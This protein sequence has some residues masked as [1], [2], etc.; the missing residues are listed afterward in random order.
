MILSRLSP[1]AVLMLS[2]LPL[3]A[4]DTRQMDAHVHGVG[5]LQIAIEGQ[6]V[7]MDITVPGAD[8]VGF[9]HAPGS[10]ADHAA[11]DAAL[12]QFADAFTLFTVAGDA[13]CTAVT[14]VNHTHGYGIE[15]DHD[16]SDEATAA[17]DHDHDHDHG[18][19]TEAAAHDHDHDHGEDHA[20]A[21]DH[22]DHDHAADA[23]HDDH[24]HDH[25]DAHDDHDHA[26]GDSH[27]EFHAVYTLTCTDPTA[28]T[29]IEF[30]YFDLFANA[31]E[32]EVEI[33]SDT[34]AMSASVLRDAPRLSLAGAM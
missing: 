25:A 9:E 30:P 24:G 1:A 16:H 8:I 11:I 29:A 26:D 12:A 20:A 15:D 5:E 17:H 7:A 34:G 33:V 4:Q 22:D 32:L 21:H 23:A 6:T 19:E 14:E 2:A 18:A 10:D 3:A 13:G 28:I 31:R 27:A